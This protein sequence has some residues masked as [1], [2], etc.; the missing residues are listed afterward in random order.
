MKNFF[1]FL[2]IFFVFINLVIAKPQKTE[3]IN[4]KNLQSKC[5]KSDF[6]AC[7][8]LGILYFNGVNVDKNI[9]MASEFFQKAC[10][11]KNAIACSNLALLYYT[12]NNVKQD[13]L[14]AISLYEKACEFGEMK[15]CVNMGI[16][17]EN[18]HGISK[19]FDKALQFYDKACQNGEMNACHNAGHLVLTNKEPNYFIGKKFFEMACEKKYAKS[20][21]NLA[22]MHFEGKG[23]RQN[24]QIAK[25][26]YGK[27]CDFGLQMGCDKFKELNEA[28]I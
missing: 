19:N 13:I 16:F 8:D 27:A 7:S 10:D 18:G 12:G 11:G 2:T 26:F 20:C 3:K 25:E 5:Q 15:A 24:K 21:F 28:G 22:I 9:T 6:K 1:V 14:T 23:T 4:I 17:Y